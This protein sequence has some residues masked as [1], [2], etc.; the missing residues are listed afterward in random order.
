MQTPGI[1]LVVAFRD[2]MH[3]RA[4]IAHGGTVGQVLLDSYLRKVWMLGQVGNTKTTRTEWSFDDVATLEHI[5]LGQPVVI[6][7]L[8]VAH[9]HTD[10]SFIV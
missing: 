10:D 3:L 4:G 1:H 7:M 8:G 5:S 9:G 2:H 6:A